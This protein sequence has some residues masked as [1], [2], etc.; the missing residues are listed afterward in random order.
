M[1]GWKVKAIIQVREE[2]IL[3]PVRCGDARKITLCKP[4]YSKMRSIL[5]VITNIELLELSSP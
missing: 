1:I 4:L 2:A 3:Y 5:W